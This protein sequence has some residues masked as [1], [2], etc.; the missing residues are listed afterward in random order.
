MYHLFIIP[1]VKYFFSFLSLFRISIE[2]I[3]LEGKGGST[4]R[5]PSQILTIVGALAQRWGHRARAAGSGLQAR[6]GEVEVV[7]SDQWGRGHGA[8]G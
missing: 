1:R 3:T 5:R 6:S 7:W 2:R 4:C 8:Y